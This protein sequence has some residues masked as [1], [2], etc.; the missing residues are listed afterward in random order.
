MRFFNQFSLQTPESVELEFTLAGIG[1]RAYALIL[2]YIFL[3]LILIVLLVF[4]AFLSLLISDTFNYFGLNSDTVNLWLFAIQ[5]LI[6]FATYVGYF[7]FFETMWQGQTPGKRIVK[8]RV[9]CDDGKTVRLQQSTLRALLRPIDDNL[10]FIGAF[11]IMLTKREKRLGDW[12]AGTIVIQEE[13]PLASTVFTL[14]PDAQALTDKLLIEADI[15]RLLPED[16]AVIR[17]YLHRRDG[18][19]PQA[20][21]ELCRKLAYRVKDIINLEEIPEDV[22]ANLFLEAVYLA[23]QQRETNHQF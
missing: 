21:I 9:I 14:S 16:F 19:I 8:I 5:L 7:V 18:M 22:T 15:S 13:R 17:E 4:W 6:I 10:F 11:L 20:R 23:Y 3:G 2:D 1:N 12:A